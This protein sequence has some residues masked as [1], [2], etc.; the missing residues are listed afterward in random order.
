MVLFAEELVE[1]ED[2]EEGGHHEVEPRQLDRQG[3]SQDAADQGAADPVAVV[4]ERQ[5]AVALL[6]VNPFGHVKGV[7]DDEGFVAETKDLDELG[8]PLAVVAVEHRH[9]VEKLA[10]AHHEG[11]HQDG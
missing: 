7:V 6:A 3:G 10:K 9:P 4:E 2:D 1:A 8:Q 5:P 11:D